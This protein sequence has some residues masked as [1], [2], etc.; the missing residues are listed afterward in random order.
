MFN[1]SEASRTLPPIGV[2]VCS[3]D[4]NA[5]D[6]RAQCDKVARV[7]A[8][9]GLRFL[10]GSDLLGDSP[11]VRVQRPPQHSFDLRRDGVIGGSRKT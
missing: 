6:P 2:F 7:L 10:D 4:V 1:N 5:E 9:Q 8:Q 11:D 3:H